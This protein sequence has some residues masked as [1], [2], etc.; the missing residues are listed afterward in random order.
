[1]VGLLEDLRYEEATVE[2]RPGDLLAAFTDGITEPENKDEEEFGEQR[3]LHL[4]EQEGTLTLP[5]AADTVLTAVRSW[6]TGSEQ[7]DDM[8]LLLARA[9]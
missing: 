6:I 9:R 4:L 2:L 1:M 7:P 8:T 3:L 5:E